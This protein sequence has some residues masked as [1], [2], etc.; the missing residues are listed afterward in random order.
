[1]DELAHSLGV[2]KGA[3]YYHIKNKEDLL[4]KCIH[5][6]F[7]IETSVLNDTLAT[8]MIGID[9]LAYAAR[10]MFA[11]QLGD[12]GPLIR[13]ATIWSLPAEKRKE[14]EATASEIRHLLGELIRSGVD[15]KS[16]REVDFFVAENTIAGAIE[17][18]PDMALSPGKVNLAQGS[19]DFFDIFFNGIAVK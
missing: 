7:N 13:Y 11:I 3:F 2:T 19:V 4:I 8:D 1:L 18:I 9:K 17:S 5:R 16:I 6:T 12:Q 10:K 15:D 14:M